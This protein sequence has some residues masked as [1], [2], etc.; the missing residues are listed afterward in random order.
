MLFLSVVYGILTW[1]TY[2]LTPQLHLLRMLLNIFSYI[3]LY[4]YA[5]QIKWLDSIKYY[6]VFFS[7]LFVTEMTGIAFLNVLGMST[8]QLIVDPITCL[9]LIPFYTAGVFIAYPAA[10][11]RHA[12]QFS[13]VNINENMANPQFRLVFIAI[14]V[15]VALLI[16]LVTQLNAGLKSS[17][18][19]KLATFNIVF[20]LVVLLNIFIL[21]KYS[22][23][24]EEK[25]FLATRDA[26]SEN[27]TG[28]LNSIR[29]QRHDFLNQLQVINSLVH[30]DAKEELKEFVTH[31]IGESSF[32]N[33][34][35]KIDNV[36]IGALLNAKLTQ[37]ELK[38]IKL[39]VDI[40]AALS[41]IGPRALYLSRIL[42]NLIDNAIEFV[43]QFGHEKI[44]K[45][46]VKKEGPFLHFSV[47]NPGSLP[48]EVKEKLF[49]P[50][51]TTKDGRH[52]GLGLFIC[53][54]LARKL[55]GKIE[56]F[57]DNAV[58]RFTLVMPGG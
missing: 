14:A 58:T 5:A 31:L 30:K 3:I 2:Q 12:I 25:L 34:V 24:A 49:E 35:L 41:H 13:F 28:L 43:D 7:F 46:T 57:S 48:Q 53:Q 26:I 36:V 21:S 22:S 9:L 39:D 27:L 20:V 38:G 18:F 10:K 52:S 56:C 32:Y 54:Q 6:A 8:E 29:G 47:I 15:Q 4:K 1:A 37:A 55:H 16:G 42:G 45:V 51:S 40:D 33:E 17:D 44:I 19:I 50:G 11:L 23:L